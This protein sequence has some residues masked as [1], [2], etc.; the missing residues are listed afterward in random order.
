M[1]ASRSILMDITS[2]Y[3]FS[4]Q[5]TVR[6][7]LAARFDWINWLVRRQRPRDKLLQSWHNSLWIMIKRFNRR[8]PG[9]KRWHSTLVDPIELTFQALSTSMHSDNDPIRSSLVENFVWN[10][11]PLRYFF[12]IVEIKWLLRADMLQTILLSKQANRYIDSW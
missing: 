11:L 10:T 4:T 1:P 5:P 3:G 8:D 6:C 12:A 9:K 7:L 2:W